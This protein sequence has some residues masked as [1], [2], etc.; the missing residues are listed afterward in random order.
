MW[1]PPPLRST[2]SRFGPAGTPCPGAPSFK[3]D[4]EEWARLRVRARDL[5]VVAAARHAVGLPV[6]LPGPCLGVV[7]VAALPGRRHIDQLSPARVAA[8]H[9]SLDR[10][11]RVC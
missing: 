2:A 9:R 8:R 11:R 7:L 6:E 10:D 3:S 1:L 4:R 5:D